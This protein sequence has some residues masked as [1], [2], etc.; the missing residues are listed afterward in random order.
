METAINSLRDVSGTSVRFFGNV[1]NASEFQDSISKQ[2]GD[3][4]ILVDLLNGK[5][6]CTM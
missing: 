5:L 3:R 6:A 4:C 2:F 1:E